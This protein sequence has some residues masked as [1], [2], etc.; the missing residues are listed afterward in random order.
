MPTL[1]EIPDIG[2]TAALAQSCGLDFVELNMNLPYFQTDTWNLSEL[3]KVARKHGVYYTVHLDE[4]LDPCDF[5]GYIREGYIR[6][7]TDAIRDSK[8][9]NVHVL[10]M[11]LSRG[12]YFTLPD[13]KVFLYAENADKYAENMRLFKAVCDDA[14]GDS[15][16]KICIENTNGYT[17]FQLT[18]L[19]ILLES[20]NFAL[21]FDIGHNHAIGGGDED[22]ILRRKDRLKHFHFHDAAGKKD[23]LALGGGDINVKKYLALAEECKARVVLET[24]TKDG[25]LRSVDYLSRL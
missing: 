22:V 19:D 12:V 3:E 11:H 21:T 5:N 20:K 18:A 15:D 14:I 2:Q 8:R 7:V 25:L 16:I 23:H 13:K 1:I 4:K 10:N 17:D 9:L 24:K 6:T